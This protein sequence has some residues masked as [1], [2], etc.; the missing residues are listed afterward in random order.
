MKVK[1]PAMAILKITKAPKA[2]AMA[3]TGCPPNAMY[4][5]APAGFTI[6]RR[7]IKGKIAGHLLL[8]LYYQSVGR[9]ACLDL[10]A[11]RRIE[12]AYCIR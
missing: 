10:M 5:C 12:E 9:G 2:S 1:L 6:K 11:S 3:N 8:S 4:R 7:M